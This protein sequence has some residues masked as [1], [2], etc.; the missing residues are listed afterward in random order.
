MGDEEQR[1]SPRI[2]RAFMV[3]YRCAAKGM[4][5]WLVSPLRDLSSGGARFISERIFAVGDELEV[6]LLL[7]A[8]RDP[9][10]LRAKIAWASAGKLGMMELGITFDAHDTAV[11]QV[12]DE[13]VAHFL[14]RHK[15]A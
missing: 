5:G 10:A 9:L 6:Q 2:P 14:G 12:I 11:Q 8:S 3:R 7:P 1:R 15:R 4:T 13:A